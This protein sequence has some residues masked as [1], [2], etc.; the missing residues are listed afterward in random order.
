MRV[1]DGMGENAERGGKRPKWFTDNQEFH[2]GAVVGALRLLNYFVFE[3]LLRIDISDPLLEIPL[4]VLR[5]R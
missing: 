5:S 3:A 1:A 4:H 2:Y